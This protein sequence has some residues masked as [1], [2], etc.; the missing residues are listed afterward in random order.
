MWVDDIYSIEYMCSLGRTIG[1]TNL[2]KVYMFYTLNMLEKYALLRAMK[3]ILGE[4]NRKF[5]MSALARETSLAVSASGYCLR[6]LEGQG[7]VKKEVVGKTHQYRADLDSF[8]TRQWKVVFSLEALHREN[9]VGKVLGKME[10]VSSILLYGSVASGRDDEKSDIDILV[11]ADTIRRQSA[12][13]P[14]VAGRELNISIYTPMEW[15]KKAQKEKAFYDNAIMN[16]LTLYG[17]KPVVL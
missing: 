15:R 17:E 8:L 2:Y 5:S 10:N 4:P 13:I 14:A 7:M 11:I 16:S 6:Y 12:G 3:K 9:I 1:R